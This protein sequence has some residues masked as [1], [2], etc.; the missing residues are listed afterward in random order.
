MRATIGERQASC[1]PIQKRRTSGL[2]PNGTH[3]EFVVPPSGGCLQNIP[4]E[5]RLKAELQTIAADKV[6][7]SGLTPLRSPDSCLAARRM[8]IAGE[9]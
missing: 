6:S 4:C 8:T 1:L 5:F 9:E 2:T 7:T 3:F